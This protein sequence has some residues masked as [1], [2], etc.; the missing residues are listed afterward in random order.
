MK[1]KE[2]LDALLDIDI[3]QNK[4]IDILTLEAK[5]QINNRRSIATLVAERH[6]HKDLHLALLR[7]WLRLQ[8]PIKSY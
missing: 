8:Q 5:R 1:S 7:T 4:Y 3:E 2:A 6:S